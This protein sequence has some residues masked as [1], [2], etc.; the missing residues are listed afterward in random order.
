MRING[1][2]RKIVTYRFTLTVL[3]TLRPPVMRTASAAV[4]PCQGD[5]SK[6]YLITDLSPF[7][8]T[9]SMVVLKVE[10][11]LDTLV[12]MIEE[13]EF[14]ESWYVFVEETE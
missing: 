13:S 1:L 14:V 9:Q 8:G 3:S 10:V 5:S 4:K 12:S 7:D 11:S 2:I 6:F